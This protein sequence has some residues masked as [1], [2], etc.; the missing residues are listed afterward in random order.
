LD[1]QK[2]LLKA[3]CTEH[4]IVTHNGVC[5]GH[6][7]QGEDGFDDAKTFADAC[8][9]ADIEPWNFLNVNNVA[10]R[11]LRKKGVWPEAF[12]QI[13]VNKRNTAF[14]GTKEKS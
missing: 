10:A 11:K 12:K 1:G 6:Q 8:K 5:W 2:E 7:Q 4:G 13:L 3:W 9:K 14:R